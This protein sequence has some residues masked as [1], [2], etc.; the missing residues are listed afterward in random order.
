VLAVQGLGFGV[1]S[2][3]NMTVIMSSVSTDA[4]SMASALGAKAR[5]LGMLCGM[6]VTAVLISINI[7]NDPV[8]Q[9]PIRFI[10]IMVTAFSMLAILTA[11]AL[12]VCCLTSTRW[13]DN[14]VH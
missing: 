8:D 9:H 10:G 5:Y 11:V 3:P 14:S 13:Q 1:F 7:G 2:A 6:L 12:V 4:T